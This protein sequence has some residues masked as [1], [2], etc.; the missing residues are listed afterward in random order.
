M[1]RARHPFRSGS[2]F[3]CCPIYPP[4][5]GISPRHTGRSTLSLS[6]LIFCLVL[7]LQSCDSSTSDSSCVRCLA[8]SV[9][10]RCKIAQCRMTM[11]PSN[12]LVNGRL[13]LDPTLMVGLVLIPVDRIT[14]GNFLSR[15]SEPLCRDIEIFH[16]S[17]LA[18]LASSL[19]P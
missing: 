2:L 3:H 10:L 18:L 6:E 13:N 16:L 9:V 15:V 5:T 1:S 8:D 19:L 11:R 4:F 12:T 17:T 7:V 14:N